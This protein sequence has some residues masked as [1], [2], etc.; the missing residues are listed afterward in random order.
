MNIEKAGRMRK[1]SQRHL[2]T[3]SEMK[4]KKKKVG[5]ACLV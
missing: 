4:R 5:K 1:K 2:F 3:E